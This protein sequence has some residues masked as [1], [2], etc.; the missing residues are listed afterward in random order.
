M[1]LSRVCSIILVNWVFL[2]VFPWKKTGVMGSSS[3]SS[4]SPQVPA[5]FVFGDSLV[6]NGN[7]NYLSSLARSNYMPYGI[8]FTG[9]PTGR[10][11]NGKTIIDF[12]GNFN[13]LTFL[14]TFSLVFQSIFNGDVHIHNFAGDFLGLPLL[15]AFVDTFTGSVD[16]LKGVNYASAAAGI[17]D[18][19]G[20]NLVNKF[21]FFFLKKLFIKIFF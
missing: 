10:F 5:M 2:F 15:P 19:T 13:L 12:L 8:D 7:N 1:G 20:K 21:L 18:E 3:S 11:S 16:I 6:D 9:G 14:L 4:S 17:L